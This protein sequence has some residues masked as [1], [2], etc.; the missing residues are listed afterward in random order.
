MC[1]AKL[2]IKD[3]FTDARKS[4]LGWTFSNKSLHDKMAEWIRSCVGPTNKNKKE[5]KKFLAWQERYDE[6]GSSQVWQG[7][8]ICATMHK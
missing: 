4:L 8:Y 6:K 5:N 3:N 1:S 7:K 2:L